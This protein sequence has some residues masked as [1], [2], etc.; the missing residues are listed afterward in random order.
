MKQKIYFGHPIN[1]YDTELES[2]LMK[3]IYEVFP[4]AEI[5]NPNQKHHAEGYKRYSDSGGRGMDYYFKEV[6]PNCQAGIFLPFRDG[7]WGAGVFGEARFIFD[8]G[9]PILKIDP[10]GTIRIFLP[11]LAEVLTVEETRA[12]IRMPSGELMPY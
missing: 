7:K 3:K 5:E 9:R 1:V 12:R 10:L 4:D 11:D 6:L 8:L 2:F